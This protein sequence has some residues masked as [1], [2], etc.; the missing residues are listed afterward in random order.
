MEYLNY[1]FVGVEDDG[2]FKF[3]K[4]SKDSSIKIIKYAMRRDGRQPS[5]FFVYNGRRNIGAEFDE[6]DA[7]WCAERSLYDDVN[8]DL[9]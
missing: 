6:D 1:S 9:Q 5:F 4:K 8:A 7:M 3:I 2:L